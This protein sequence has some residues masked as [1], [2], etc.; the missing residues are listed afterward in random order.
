MKKFK[1]KT[2]E[3][4]IKHVTLE[5]IKRGIRFSNRKKRPIFI[6]KTSGGDG[7]NVN[8]LNPNTTDGIENLEKFFTPIRRHYTFS[9]LGSPEEKNSISWRVL[10]LPLRRRVLLV[11]QVFI[12]FLLKGSPFKNILYR[13]MGIHN[14]KQ[15]V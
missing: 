5:I 4:V 10:N 1:N 15:T 3:E 14:L 13:W 8:D 6:S 11:I 7:T 12:S 2:P 9:G